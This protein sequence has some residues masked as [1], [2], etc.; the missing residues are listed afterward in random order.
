[1]ISGFH[2]DDWDDFR[3]GSPTLSNNGKNSFDEKSN[4]ESEVIAPLL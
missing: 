3:N 1:M 2:G 4:E